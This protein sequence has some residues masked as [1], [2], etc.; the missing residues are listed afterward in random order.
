MHPVLAQRQ[1][2]V[3]RLERFPPR[4]LPRCY[5]GRCAEMKARRHSISLRGSARER[6]QLARGLCLLVVLTLG[7]PPRSASASPRSSLVLGLRCSDPVG[8]ASI[9]IRTDRDLLSP[10]WITAS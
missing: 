3:F 7:T 5:A 4:S 1:S 10:L 9:E 8:A 2:R 6:V